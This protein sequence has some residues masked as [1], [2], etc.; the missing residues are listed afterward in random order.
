M[1]QVTYLI[2]DTTT[3]TVQVQGADGPRTLFEDD[4]VS[5]DQELSASQDGLDTG[6]LVSQREIWTSRYAAALNAKHN[7]ELTPTQAYFLAVRVSREL[8]ALL[9]N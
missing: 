7:T 4:L 2:P 8:R 6:A 1:P 3:V 9:G 5:L